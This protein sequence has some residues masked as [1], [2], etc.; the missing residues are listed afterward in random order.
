M[1]NMS[2]EDLHKIFLEKNRLP[3]CHKNAPTDR[4]ARQDGHKGVCSVIPDNGTYL[5]WLGWLCQ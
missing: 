1:D 2:D 4:C 3:R 5:T